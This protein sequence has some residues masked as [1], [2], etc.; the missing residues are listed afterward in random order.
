[1]GNLTEILKGVGGKPPAMAGGGI[2]PAIGPSQAPSIPPAVGPAPPPAAGST[3]PTPVGQQSFTAADMQRLYTDQKKLADIPRAL[4]GVKPAGTDG[5]YTLDQLKGLNLGWMTERSRNAWNSMLGGL[6][7]LGNAGKVGP[8]GGLP[9]YTPASPD[10]QPTPPA[11]IQPTPSTLSAPWVNL[12]RTD[13]YLQAMF[14][15][16]LGSSASKGGGR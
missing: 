2:P 5:G 10:P 8:G 1:M 6:A 7:G 11:P 13:P 14:M 15:N 16:A 9:G 4:R 12:L 3:P